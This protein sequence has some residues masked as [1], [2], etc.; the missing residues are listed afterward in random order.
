MS[1]GKIYSF[2]ESPR[3]QILAA[4]CKSLKIDCEFVDIRNAPEA[5]ELFPLGKVPA[6]VGSNG[7]KLNETVP[8]IQYCMSIELILFDSWRLT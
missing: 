1:A 2:P 8:I 4:L 5:A 6:L 7:Y 3:C